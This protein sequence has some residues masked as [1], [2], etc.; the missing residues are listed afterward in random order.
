MIAINRVKGGNLFFS[1]NRSSFSRSFSDLF[2]IN[3]IVIAHVGNGLL[4]FQHI[5]QNLHK[6]ALAL[7]M[8]CH[9]SATIESI[10][11]KMVAQ[12]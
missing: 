12:S 10:S 8:R 11:C 7:L 3:S 6:F 4:Y 9:G 1:L 5:I 2:L